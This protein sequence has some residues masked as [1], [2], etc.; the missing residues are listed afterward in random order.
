MSYSGFGFTLSDIA[1]I[2]A[3]AFSGY[4]FLVGSRRWSRSKKSEE[5]KTARE[6]MDRITTKE[7]RLDEYMESV[8]ENAAAYDY[9][10]HLYLMNNVLEEIQ[11]YGLLIKNDVIEES[12][13][14]KHDRR[15]VAEIWR[16]IN[17]GGKDVQS[18]IRKNDLVN[19]YRR[20]IKKHNELQSYEHDNND[21]W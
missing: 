11:Y 20:R 16:T 3:L 5:I 13:L 10:R 9:G 14:L 19:T 7:D 21:N 2:S 6:L 18:K 1:A 12:E 4:T 17:L 8:K 15:N